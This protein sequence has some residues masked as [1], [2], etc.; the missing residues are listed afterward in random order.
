MPKR[1]A[2]GF[3]LIELLVAITIISSVIAITT[4][5]YSNYLLNDRRFAESSELYGDL[6][7]VSDG[8]RARVKEN[9]QESG[10]LKVNDTAC[11]WSTTEKVTED[12]KGFDFSTGQLTS[13]GTKFT[14]AQLLVSCT[15][16]AKKAPDFTMDVLIVDSPDSGFV[17]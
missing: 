9:R 6:L 7:E 14:L 8:I 16:G 10:S 13:S 15:N 17:G 4:V 12:Q 2:D 1:N 5:I 11:E 3:T